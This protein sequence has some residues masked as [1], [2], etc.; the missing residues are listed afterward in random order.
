[1]RAT[2]CVILKSRTGLS[3]KNT[4]LVSSQYQSSGSSTTFPRTPL[5][6]IVRQSYLELF[7]IL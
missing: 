5:V 1:M 6:F 2:V 3:S 4:G 7:Q